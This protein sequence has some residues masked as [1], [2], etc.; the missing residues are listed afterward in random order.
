MRPIKKIRK[1]NIV[2]IKNVFTY[3]LR[4]YRLLFLLF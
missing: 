3:Y 2:V 4:S 1:K